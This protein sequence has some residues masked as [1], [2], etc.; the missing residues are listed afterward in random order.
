MKKQKRL[1]GII[2]ATIRS[3]GGQTF[4]MDDVAEANLWKLA[5]RLERGTLRGS[6]D[7]R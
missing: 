3:D 7:R 5:G 2:C 4:R 1:P 6:G